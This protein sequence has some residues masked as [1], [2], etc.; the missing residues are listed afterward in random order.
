MARTLESVPALVP[1][2]PARLM[3]QHRGTPACPRDTARCQDGARGWGQRGLPSPP[4]APGSAGPYG[5]EIDQRDDRRADPAA[6]RAGGQLRIDD[7]LLQAVRKPTLATGGA[8][9]RDALVDVVVGRVPATD[10]DAHGRAPAPGGGA[11]PAGPLA[12]DR[13]DDRLGAGRVPEVHHDL[14]EN[15]VVEHAEPGLA[16]PVGETACQLA[17][18]SHQGGHAVT[19]ERRQHGPYLHAPGALR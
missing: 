3:T 4:R 17:G 13:G 8:H 2:G 18:P 11:A 19:A 5:P 7:R 1:A 15:D 10:A 12:L 16:H 6:A 14:V 9:G